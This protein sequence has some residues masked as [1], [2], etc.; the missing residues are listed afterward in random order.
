MPIQDELNARLK[1]AMRAKDK[2]M[3]NLIRMLKS[4][5]TQKT[6]APGFSREVD[7]ALWTEVIVAYA[8]SQSKA[9]SQFE[10]IDREG[11]FEH[12]EQIK[13]ELQALEEWL[14]SKADEAT[15]RGWVQEVLD[16]MG[17]PGAPFGAVMGAVMRAHKN[18]VDPAMLRAIIEEKIG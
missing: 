1:D 17:G 18:E 2:Q 10:G 13:W 9:L 5:M 16:G 8:K 7:D 15:V 6:T 14:P 11:A 3:L 4:R 12:I